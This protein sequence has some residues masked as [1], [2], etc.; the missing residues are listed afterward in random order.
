MRVEDTYGVCPEL[1]TDMARAYCDGLQTDPDAAGA[2]N[3][4]GN[5]SVSAMVKHWPG[6]GPCFSRIES[7]SIIKADLR[8]RMLPHGKENLR[9]SKLEG[10]GNVEVA[11]KGCKATLAYERSRSE[12]KGYGMC[13]GTEHIP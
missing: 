8:E 5:K 9:K 3:G 1:V 7:P 12:A 4:W 11:G 13:E 2:A 6:G 10:Q